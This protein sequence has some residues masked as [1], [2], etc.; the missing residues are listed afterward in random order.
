[1]HES[2]AS[3]LFLSLPL[4]APK[5]PE[6]PNQGTSQSTLSCHSSTL[7]PGAA[8]A[9]SRVKA[10]LQCLALFTM[11]PDLSLLP[12]SWFSGVK[13][14]ESSRAVQLCRFVH[15]TSLC[16]LHSRETWELR[17]V[18]CSRAPIWRRTKTMTAVWCGCDSRNG[19]SQ[20]V[21][22]SAMAHGVDIWVESSQEY[23][24]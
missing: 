11:S 21:W 3:S 24:D 8:P 5:W 13:Q 4:I 7:R 1:M 10:E 18:Q 12:F 22:G 16:L 23:R 17:T 2:A 9:A 19:H 6:S 15:L 20:P 14:S